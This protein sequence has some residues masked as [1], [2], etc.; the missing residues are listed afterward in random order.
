MRE[1]KPKIDETILLRVTGKPPQSNR[2]KSA[3]TAETA[4]KSISEEIP[5]PTTNDI[6]DFFLDAKEVFTTTDEPHQVTEEEKPTVDNT[7]PEQKN[8]IKEKPKVVEEVTSTAPH[9][10]FPDKPTIECP[11]CGFFINQPDEAEI[12]EEDKISYIAAIRQ[13]RPF[14]KQYSLFDGSIYAAFRD[15][16]VQEVDAIFMQTCQDR[17]A[18]IVKTIHDFYEQLLRYRLAVQLLKYGAIGADG[19]SFQLAEGLSP[20][21]NPRAKT[22]WKIEDEKN[23]KR[24]LLRAVEEYVRVSI[25]TDHAVYNTLLFQLKKFNR[26]ISKLSLRAGDHNFFSN[27][28]M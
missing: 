19:F 2:P 20:E 5:P 6:P 10:A 18:G 17:D 9:D 24:S 3:H 25:I 21:T 8:E 15:L 16:T 1:Q 11:H 23:N 22:Y 4:A 7:Q 14:Q 28:Q 12:T 27:R 13:R 26:I